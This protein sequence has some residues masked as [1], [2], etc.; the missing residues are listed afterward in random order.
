MGLT[1]SYPVSPPIFGVVESDEPLIQ[2]D[3]L[4]ILYPQSF[5]LGRTGKFHYHSPIFAALKFFENPYRYATERFSAIFCDCPDF[6]L[7]LPAI[8][9]LVCTQPRKSHG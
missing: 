7:P 1:G 8:F 5:K 3:F 6:N 2:Q 4:S 9:Y